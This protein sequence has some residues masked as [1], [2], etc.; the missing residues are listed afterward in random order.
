M[1]VVDLVNVIL[2]WGTDGAAHGGD[3]D[4]DGTVELYAATDV[5]DTDFTANVMD[6]YPDGRAVKKELTVV[7][8]Q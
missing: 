6:V 3:V 7:S 4:G 1:D 2:D 5:R 8:Q